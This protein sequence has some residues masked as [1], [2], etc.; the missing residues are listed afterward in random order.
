MKKNLFA[1]AVLSLGFTAC[2]DTTAPPAYATIENTT[3]APELGVDL[4]S[5]TKTDAGVYYRDITIGTGP[6][7]A[8]QQDSYM[9]Y[10]AYLSTGAQFDSLKA[11][12]IPAHFVTAATPPRSR[13]SSPN[14]RW[15]TAR[16]SSTWS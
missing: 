10:H 5:S 9:Y 12:A 11:P 8:P 2:L 4:S 15:T 3:F 6:V 14:V 1:L 7:I 16:P 13:S